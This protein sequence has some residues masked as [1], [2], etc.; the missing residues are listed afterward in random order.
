MEAEDRSEYLM[1]FPMDMKEA[2][3][4]YIDNGYREVGARRPSKCI[5]PSIFRSV[6]IYHA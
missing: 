5:V 3:K 4:F 1:I 6:P 2:V